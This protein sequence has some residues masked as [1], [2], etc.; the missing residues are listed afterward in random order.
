[1]GQLTLT[2]PARPG[3][4]GGNGGGGAGGGPGPMSR[5]GFGSLGTPV[6]VRVNAFDVSAPDLTAY[7]FDVK[8]HPTDEKRPARLNRAIFQHLMRSQ[9]PFNGVAVAYDGK[10]QAYSPKRLPAPSGSWTINLPEADG[11][12]ARAGANQFR[13]ELALVRPIQLGALRNFVSGGLAAASVNEDAV[14]SAIQALNI[15]IQMGPMSAHPSR[16]PSFFLRGPH[17][18]VGPGSVEYWRGYYTSLRPGIG[19][20]F[21]NVDLTAAPMFAPGN[22]AEVILELAKLDVHRLQL[23][24]LSRMPP[25]VRLK[26]GRILKGIRITRTVRDSDGK[27]PKRKI[28]GFTPQGARAT[29][30]Q[31]A[32]GTTT[33]VFDYFRNQFNVQLRHPDFPCVL[34]SKRAAWPIEICDIDVG[35]KYSGKLAPQQ[36]LAMLQFTTIKPRQRLQMVQQSISTI[37][38]SNNQAMGQWGLR[39]SNQPIELTA[40][41]LPPPPL[42]YGNPQ[43]PLR[44]SEGQWNLKGQRFNLPSS[45]DRWAVMVFTTQQNF[46]PPQ[47]QNSIR[48]FVQQLQTLGIRVAN[49]QPQIHY[50]G[51]IAPGKV[52]SFIRSKVNPRQAPQLLVCYLMD[53]PSPLY[54]AIKRFGDLSVGVATQCMNIGKARGQ[55]PQYYAN[56]ALKVNVKLAGVNSTTRLGAAT[57]KPTVVFGIDV[58]HAAPGSLAPSVIGVVA[59][60]DPTISRFASRMAVQSSRQEVITDLGPI[61]LDL[62]Q[63]FKTTAKVKPQRLIF[64]RDG[65]SEGQFGAALS[66]EV[67]AI[68]LACQ[69]IEPSFKPS[70]TYIVCG[71]RHHISIFP[72]GPDAKE[73]KTDNVKA[74]TVIDTVITSPFH[75][76]WYLQSHGSL[77]GTSRSSHYT[78]LVDDS[79]FSADELQQLCNNICYTY[80]RCT[81]SVSYATPAY[82]ADR[83]AER[84]AL[85]LADPN[86]DATSV[87]SGRSAEHDRMAAQILATYRGR[88]SRIHPNHA[89]SL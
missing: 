44:P 65:L 46:P 40:R 43:Q 50:S 18:P 87:A 19:R 73:Q 63:Q 27:F 49:H 57:D 17:P 80:A 71:K 89:T 5:P 88:L 86:D 53:K 62:L 42:T 56:L 68:R 37:F 33:N 31:L 21:I 64:F 9:N 51:Q 28:S 83:L 52:E 67:N 85:L 4:G 2:G 38:P 35:Q 36:I 55:G 15:A 13:V 16:G 84:A 32:N 77:L 6:R 45:I 1:M 58:S 81:R 7:Q 34:I 14:M 24:D 61:I 22:L 29:E 23:T 72:V 10:A 66:H 47:A 25:Q 26:L 60:M 69:K 76:D 12:P 39:I 8:I 20:A 54:G 78:C 70:I 11:S 82:Y 74:G 3:G 48:L 30:F 75:F 79:H 59:S 41:Q